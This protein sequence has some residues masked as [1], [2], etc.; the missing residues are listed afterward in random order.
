[1]C[2][3]SGLQMFC[4][5]SL[6]FLL[7]C[8]L[9]ISESRTLGIHSSLPFSSASGLPKCDDFT[10]WTIEVLYD[11]SAS[12]THRCLVTSSVIPL[13]SHSVKSA[14]HLQYP[15]RDTCSACY[16]K[17]KLPSRTPWPSGRKMVGISSRNIYPKD[18]LGTRHYVTW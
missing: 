10:L 15:S 17:T 14:H 12:V 18:A 2:T 8:Y 5:C 3:Y 7:S 11:S 6:V 9:S 16:I 13:P 4:V 1:V